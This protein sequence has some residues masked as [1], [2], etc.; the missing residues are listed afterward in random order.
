M[1]LFGH[2][3]HQKKMDSYQEA[4]GM[5]FDC[6]GRAVEND[7]GFHMFR[8]EEIT[9]ERAKLLTKN[10]ARTQEHDLT[11]D[12]YFSRTEYLLDLTSLYIL[13]LSRNVSA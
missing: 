9:L 11:D 10:I 7:G 5:R 8:K 3:D 12:I 6:F 4:L 2:P 1:Y 13:N